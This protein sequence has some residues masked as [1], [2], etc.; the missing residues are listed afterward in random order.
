MV[1][2]VDFDGTIT[3]ENLFPEIGEL[4]KNA[5]EV[6]QN[7]QKHG[8]KCFLWTCRE[9][10]SLNDAITF[11]E[12]KG[13]KMDGY[14]VSPYDH[15]NKGRKPI[16]DLYIDDR[17]FQIK[18]TGIDWKRIETYILSDK[19][20]ENETLNKLRNNFKEVI[21]TNIKKVFFNKKFGIR[22]TFNKLS[23]NKLSCLKSIRKSEKNG[24]T[25]EEHFLAVEEIKHLFEF[26]ECI[27]LH[28]NQKNG[29]PVAVHSCVAKIA[30]NIFAKMDV[31]TWKNGG[32]DE[33]YIDLYLSK[34]VE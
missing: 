32:R 1:I 14:N 22:F 18:D 12:S 26:S 4:R 9:G 25:P 13:L 15:I 20:A 17:N 31:T 11:L 30:D 24:F 8:H 27:S 3:K 6:I 5:I 23:V 2:A 7:L 34:E 10:K 33:G 28:Y 19:T 16:A 29:Q 21:G